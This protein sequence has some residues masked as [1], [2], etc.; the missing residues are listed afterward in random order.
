[1]NNRQG[2]AEK[3]RDFL[4]GEL[5]QF[6]YLLNRKAADDTLATLH[7]WAEAIR[8]RERD[9]ALGR[10]PVKDEKTVAIVEDL[11]RVLVTK[12]LNDATFSIRACAESG[13]MATA[14][15]LVAAIIRG[16]RI[17]TRNEE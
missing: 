12:I 14:E 10:F 3:A 9:R 17:C 1:M 4:I 6:V 15:A 2:E 13:D 5:E 8:I 7:T 11:S 16:D